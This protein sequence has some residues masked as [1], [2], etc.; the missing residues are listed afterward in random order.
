MKVRN[1]DMS[2]EIKNLQEAV[3]K[4]EQAIH[5]VKK[6]QQQASEEKQ[7]LKSAIRTAYER[8]D[9]A[10]KNVRQGEG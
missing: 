7:V 3:L 5:I 8:I 1:N 10:L 2:E 9:K 4:L 6:S